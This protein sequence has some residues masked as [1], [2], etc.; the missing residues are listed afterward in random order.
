MATLYKANG[1]I[2]TVKPLNGEGFTLEE[3]QGLVGGYV[4]K[5][6]LSAEQFILCDEDGKSKNLPVNQNATDLWIKTF[7]YATVFDPVLLGPVLLFNNKD[8]ELR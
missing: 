2:E 8:N 1:E 3:L 4:E 6:N 7:P 5:V